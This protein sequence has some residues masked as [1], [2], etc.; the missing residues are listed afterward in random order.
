MT[1]TNQK[2]NNGKIQKA[3][4]KIDCQKGAEKG[5]AWGEANPANAKSDFI[6]DTY[7]QLHQNEPDLK[8]TGKKEYA[9]NIDIKNGVIEVQYNPESIKYR[10]G[11]S[12]DTDVKSDMEEGQAVRIT[13]VTSESVVDMSFTLVFHTK[14]Q[15]DQYVREQME[16]IMDMIC[17]SPTRWVEFS[18]ADIH[19]EG[20]LVSFSGEYD[21]FDRAGV[22]ISGHMDITIEASMKAE[23]TSKILDQ[24]ED[25]HKDKI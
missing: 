6:S 5:S 11:I 7:R 15:E 21:M 20:R 8:E 23:R 13:T 18:W 19:M 25:K 9:G 24:L 1:G 3:I 14:S 16:M 22:P 10:T 2:F 17:N 12:E 4:L